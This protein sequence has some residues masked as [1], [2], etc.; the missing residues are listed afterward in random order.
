MTPYL[1]L[2]Q[3]VTVKGGKEGVVSALDWDNGR[4]VS[5]GLDVNEPPYGTQTYHK[6]VEDIVE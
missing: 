4:V 1:K 5:F 6:R 2:K 3:K